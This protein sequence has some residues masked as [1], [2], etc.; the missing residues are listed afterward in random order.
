MDIRCD[1]CETSSL[2]SY[3]NCYDCKDY[4]YCDPCH[5]IRSQLSHDESHRFIRIVPSV[6][7]GDNIG[8]DHGIQ[9][10]TGYTMEFHSDGNLCIYKR[11][12]GREWEYVWESGTRGTPS[13]I[14]S[15]KQGTMQ[16]SM[17]NDIVWEKSAEENRVLIDLEDDALMVSYDKK[18]FWKSDLAIKENLMGEIFNHPGFRLVYIDDNRKSLV[19]IQG[20]MPLQHDVMEHG[21]RCISHLWGD[22]KGQ[23]WSQHGIS[24][25]NHK[26]FIREEKRDKLMY[27]FDH[28]KGYWWM[29]VFCTNQE[30]ENKPLDVMDKIYANCTECICLIDGKSTYSS[31]QSEINVDGIYDEGLFGNALRRDHETYDDVKEDFCAIFPLFSDCRWATRMWILQEAMLPPVV[32]CTEETLH[33]GRQH[34]ISMET[35]SSIRY[36]NKRHLRHHESGSFI[37]L[38]RARTNLVYNSR[39]IY[40]LATGSGRSCEEPGDYAYSICGIL[41]TSIEKG[42]LSDAAIFALLKTLPDRE[43][44]VITKSRLHMFNNGPEDTPTIESSWRNAREVFSRWVFQGQMY[45]FGC[46]R[47]N[48]YSQIGFHIGR[49]E[50]KRSLREYAKRYREDLDGNVSKEDAMALSDGTILRIMYIASSFMWQTGITY[51]NDKHLYV[52]EKRVIITSKELDINIGDEIALGQ[53]H[54]FHDD[55]YLCDITEDRV[56][57]PFGRVIKLWGNGAD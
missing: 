9:S 23:E 41:K 42:L 17:G 2:R 30:D 50:S 47:S 51:W 18:I 29:D 33:H 11:S 37:E 13:E 55:A 1:E 56:V 36:R 45:T 8:H 20:N 48:S 14:L 27:L 28:F 6:L 26:V 40:D 12:Y 15:N 25:V 4:D 53:R 49:L 38:M 21:Y 32:F 52:T 34:M 7:N 31:D 46:D 5:M 57:E 39:Q 54:G 35:M 22:A 10:K 24:G 19:D 3:Y 16:L 43:M 44:F